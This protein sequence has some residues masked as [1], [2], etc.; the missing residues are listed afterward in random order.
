MNPT[1]VLYRV[2][3]YLYR[4]GMIKTSTFMT[5]INRFLF[6]AWIPSSVD[7]GKNFKLGYGG[8]GVVIHS[9]TIIGDNFPD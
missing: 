2:G 9:N 7:I 4:K 6:A 8:L 1:L 3:N 5:Y